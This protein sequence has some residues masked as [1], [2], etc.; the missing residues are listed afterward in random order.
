MRIFI[1]FLTEKLGQLSEDTAM[2]M[3]DL[4]VRLNRLDV[5]VLNRQVANRQVAARAMVMAIMVVTAMAACMTREV[6]NVLL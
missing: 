2:D 1:L 6:Q 4:L 5:Y 3:E